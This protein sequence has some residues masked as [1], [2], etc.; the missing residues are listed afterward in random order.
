MNLLK[1]YYKYIYTILTIIFRKDK[2]TISQHKRVF[3][4]KIFADVSQP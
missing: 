1:G 4:T 3:Q 2:N